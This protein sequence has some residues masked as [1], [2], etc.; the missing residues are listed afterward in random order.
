MPARAPSTRQGAATIRR[1]AN[2]AA[3][4]PAGVVGVVL[5]VGI[6]GHGEARAHRRRRD[7]RQ[8]VRIAAPLPDFLVP[9]HR[10]AGDVRHRIARTIGRAVVDHDH[11]RAAGH[12]RQHDLAHVARVVVDRNHE[13]ERAPGAEA[14]AQGWPRRGA[15]RPLRS[16]RKIS[17]VLIPPNAKLLFMAILMGPW[18]ALPST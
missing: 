2:S 8:P 1:R 7:G 11:R 16:A 10:R 13:S 9:H 6:H 18:R 17:E 3:S 14:G 12:R 4:K 5:S 15:G